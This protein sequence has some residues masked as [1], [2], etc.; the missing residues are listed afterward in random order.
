MRKM[1]KV[2]H[3]SLFIQLNMIWCNGKQSSVTVVFDVAIHLPKSFDWQNQMNRIKY[4]VAH[5]V[6]M[7][8]V[9]VDAPNHLY[10]IK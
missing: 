4:S 7:M 10:I 5:V 6:V 2:V 1:L 9:E 8:H 3:F